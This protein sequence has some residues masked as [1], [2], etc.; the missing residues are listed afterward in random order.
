MM[1]SK[2]QNDEVYMNFVW[3]KSDFCHTFKNE[4]DLKNKFNRLLATK[5]E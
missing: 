1:Q 2:H 3:N 5:I 4:L